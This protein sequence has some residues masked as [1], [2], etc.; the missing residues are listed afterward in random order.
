M[1]GAVLKERIQRFGT[2]VGENCLYVS[3]VSEILF[4]SCNNFNFSDMEESSPWVTL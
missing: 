2:S 1:Q 3:H 4:F